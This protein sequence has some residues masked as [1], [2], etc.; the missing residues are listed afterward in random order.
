[1]IKGL[2]KE[3]RAL[4]SNTKGKLFLVVFRISHA[5]CRQGSPFFIR[6]PVRVVYVVIVRWVLGIDIPE[7]AAIG[8]GFNLYHGFGVVIHE[9]AV[10]GNDVVLRH[11]CTI[12]VARDGGQAPIIGDRVQIGANSVIIGGI[13][14][15]NDVTVGA[16]SVVIR[17]VEDGCI[18]AGNPAKVVRK[19]Q[20]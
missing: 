13:K 8:F 4:G 6:I 14:I 17:D 2:L 19:C 7:N 5:A 15:G 18:V 10:I 3:V 16:G 11:N 20:N 9:S 1:M 12:G